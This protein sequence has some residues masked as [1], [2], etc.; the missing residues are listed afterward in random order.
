MCM[1]LFSEMCLWAR[2]SPLN[3]GDDPDP[4]SKLRFDV[5]IPLYMYW[6]Y[7]I[8]NKEMTNG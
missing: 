2:T 6:A 7:R 8:Q 4:E 1:E 5:Y 3:F